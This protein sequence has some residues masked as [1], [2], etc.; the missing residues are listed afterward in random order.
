MIVPFYYFIFQRDTEPLPNECLNTSIDTSK[1]NNHIKI[2]PP[3]QQR[4]GRARN[5]FV[6][7]SFDFIVALPAKKSNNRSNEAR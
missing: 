4:I 2:A 7:I 6:C 5:S 1:K 3:I